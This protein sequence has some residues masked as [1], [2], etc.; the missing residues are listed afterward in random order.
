[1]YAVLLKTIHFIWPA[2][3]AMTVNVSAASD[4]VS[5]APQLLY[6]TI[7]GVRVEVS[8]QVLSRGGNVS[9]DQL[10]DTAPNAHS[11]RGPNSTFLPTAFIMGLQY[12]VRVDVEVVVV[13]EDG[14]TSARYPVS[15]FRDPASQSDDNGIISEE[16]SGDGLEESEGSEGKR[17]NVSSVTYIAPPTEAQMREKGWPESPALNE[18]CEVCPAGWASF[19][20]NAEQCQMCPPGTFSPEVRLLILVCFFP[21]MLHLIVSRSSEK[22]NKQTTRLK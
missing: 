16:E 15:L 13:A 7:E 17:M 8:G 11:T 18:R 9:A 20:V 2:G 5:L 4:I 19:E 14:V 10:E 22:L 21:S 12:G 3:V 1:M 6:P